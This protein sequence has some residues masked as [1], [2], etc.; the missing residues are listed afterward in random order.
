MSVRAMAWAFEQRVGSPM[1]KLVLLKLADH[2]D[3]NGECFP[4]I[5]RIAADTEMN[6]AYPVTADTHC[7]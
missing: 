2:A 5:G 6:R 4:S 7:M 1:A 3:E